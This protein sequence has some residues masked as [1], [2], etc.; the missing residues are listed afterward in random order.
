M[1]RQ[2][3]TVINCG[4]QGREEGIAIGVIHFGSHLWTAHQ[5]LNN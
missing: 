2:Q 1:L 3:L 4:M 5:E